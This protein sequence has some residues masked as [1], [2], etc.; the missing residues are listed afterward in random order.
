[1]APEKKTTP[2]SRAFLITP[3]IIRF[4]IQKNNVVVYLK[5]SLA[6]TVR[7]YASILVKSGPWHFI[8]FP[9]YSF[10]HFL[11]K[12]IYIIN[13]GFLFVLEKI[14]GFDYKKN[15]LFEDMREIC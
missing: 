10:Y 6:L 11:S 14:D 13:L 3:P 1:M 15:M 5:K 12:T 7:K 8:L 2:F 9:H 4:F